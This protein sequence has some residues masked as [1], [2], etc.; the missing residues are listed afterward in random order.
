M[1]S[2]SASSPVRPVSAGHRV[3]QVALV[4]GGQQHLVELALDRLLPREV[5]VPHDLLGDGR[6]ALAGG[7]GRQVDVR[8]PG[9][10]HGIDALVRPELAVLGGDDGVLEHL[11][12][13]LALHGQGQLELAE[14]G[15]LIA[16]AA[17]GVRQVDA[18][19]LQTPARAGLGDRAGQVAEDQR[20]EPDTGGRHHDDG[21]TDDHDDG[22]ARRRPEPPPP[23]GA[24]AQARGGGGRRPG[25]Q[26]VRR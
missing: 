12:H 24:A 5:L 9:D 14:R 7:A 19:R 1:A 15:D 11:G 6:G 18:R 13:V 25:H 21:Q 22:D 8:R 23:A 20:A 4:A 16:P 2:R 26:A 17:V 3:D 10:A